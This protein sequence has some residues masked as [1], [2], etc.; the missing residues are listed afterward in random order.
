MF[1]RFRLIVRFVRKAEAA[2]PACP[3]FVR[4]EAQTARRQARRKSVAHRRATPALQGA[5]HQDSRT[6]LR[7]NDLPPLYAYHSLELGL[8]KLFSES[9]D[10]QRNEHDGERR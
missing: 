5:L 1:L 4:K 10:A 2:R 7:K 3:V 6:R 8:A 9:P